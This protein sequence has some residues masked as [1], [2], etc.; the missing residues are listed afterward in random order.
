[1]GGAYTAVCNDVNSIAFNPAGLGFLESTEVE[2]V[3]NNWIQ[4]ISNQYAAVAIP[5][6]AF[7]TLGLEVTMLSVN[8]MV[9]TDNQGNTDGT[10]FQSS[11]MSSSLAYAKTFSGAFSAGFKLKMLNENI[12]NIQASGCAADVGILFRTSSSFDI[13][14]AEQNIG[15]GIKFISESDPLPTTVKAGIAYR[16]IDNMVCAFDVN[17]TNDSDTYECVGAEYVI[18]C[19][20]KLTFP[21]R[22][23]YR[24]GYDTGDLSGFSAG[25]GVFYNNLLSVDIAWAPMGILGD[26]MQFGL[27]IKF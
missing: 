22:L 21:I 2:L 25:A 26:S 1:M 20:R 16:P 17:Q 15:S 6:K 3:Q 18:V 13:G 5:L 27:G 19:D 14:I 7:G 12:D 24:T 10:K 4:D 23:G 8:G 11:D 9:R